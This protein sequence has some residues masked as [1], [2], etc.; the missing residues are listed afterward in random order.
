MWC[1]SCRILKSKVAL[2]KSQ[3]DAVRVYISRGLHG[4]IQPVSED[5]E[6]R[7]ESALSLMPSIESAQPVVPMTESAAPAMPST[8][9][10]A[11]VTQTSCVTEACTAVISPQLHTFPAAT[12]TSITAALSG[13]PCSVVNMV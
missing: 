8:D 2:N 9:C 5:V 4:A 1:V 7:S 3:F 13:L 6:P 10:S 12:D 11:A